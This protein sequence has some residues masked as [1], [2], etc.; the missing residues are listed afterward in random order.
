MKTA[1]LICG[2]IGMAI[3]FYAIWE[4]ARMPADVVM[5]IGPS[6]FPSIMA[7]LLVLFSAALI[8]NA[9]RGRSKGSVTPLRLSD[10]GVQRGLITFAA[11][12]VFC[13]TLDPIGFI[14][15]SIVFL[16][17]MAWVLGKRAWR[18]LLLA[19]P[20]ITVA[21]WLI[22]EKVLHLALPPGLLIDIL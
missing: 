8:V 15:M 13:A 16:A 12:I 2:L 18:A 17:F 1:D 3:G 4:G 14:P 5:K 20:L 6:Y 19:P 22:F 11:A 9:L 7:G 21:V 10:K